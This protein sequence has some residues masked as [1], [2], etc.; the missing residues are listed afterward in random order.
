MIILDALFACLILHF[1]GKDSLYCLGL[2]CMVLFIRVGLKAVRHF[3]MCE[4]IVYYLGQEAEEEV[5]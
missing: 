3:D 5:K 2:T 1:F 4:Q